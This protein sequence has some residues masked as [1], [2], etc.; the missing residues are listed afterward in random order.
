MAKVTGP[1]FCTEARG[2]I[3]KSIIYQHSKHSWIV[4]MF[5]IPKYTRN[6]LQ[7][8]I[9]KWFKDVIDY[10]ADMA[11]EER[12]LWALV[13]MNIKEYN[14][15]RVKQTSRA[16]RCHL[17]HYALITESFIWNGS[18]FPPELI[19]WFAKDEIEGYE[20]LKLDLETLTGLEF[21]D[22][23]NP[24]FFPY[25]GI[26]TSEG[27]PGKGGLVAGLANVRGAAIAIDQDFFYSLPTWN[28]NVL[29]AHELTHALMLQHG[30]KYRPAVLDSE[31]I[32]NECG[33]RIANGELEPIYKYKNKTLSEWV[34]DPEC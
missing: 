31:T 34:P 32:A 3:G 22:P 10:F 12:F 23:V 16:P 7:D 4:R 30:W 2:T 24:Y 9:R 15:T 29:I 19:Q 33:V 20:Q 17:S 28:Q 1:L 13:L 27:H 18:P 26:I 14:A 25:L 5:F 21:C 11:E 6:W 8:K